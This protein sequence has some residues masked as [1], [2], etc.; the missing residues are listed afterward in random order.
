[1]AL[2]REVIRIRGHRNRSLAANPNPNP[3]SAAGILAG[4]P[5]G[6]HKAVTEQ[7]G[8]IDIID[9][10]TKSQ[11]PESQVPADRFHVPRS[12]EPSYARHRGI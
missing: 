2:Q 3:N 11:N 9:I 1:M 6:T 7:M 10:I 8:V 12:A 5:S 4:D